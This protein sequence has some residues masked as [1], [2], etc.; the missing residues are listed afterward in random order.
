MESETNQHTYGSYLKAF[1]SKQALALE[2]IAE[3]TK[4]AVHCL[5]AIEE[6]DDDRLP[7]EA[8]VKSFIRSYAEMVGADTDEA[9]SMYL[10]DLKQRADAKKQLLKREAKLSILRRILM[11]AGLIAIILLLV[12]T[13]VIFLE[14]GPTRTPAETN[15]NV[16]P[17]A[18]TSVTEADNN[19][20]PAESSPGKL[21]L[22]VVATKQTWLKV[23]IDSQNAR[24]Y[25]LKPEDRLELEGTKNFN[26]MIGDAT[27]LEILLNDRPVNIYGNSGQVVSLKIP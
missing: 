12:R 7:P 23:I 22:Q 2:T 14:P 8:Y 20:W 25:E 19:E 10:S 17:E 1:R 24:S 9:I 3:Q 6:S 21:K 27:G 15:H 16:I 18:A 4:I 5:R 13:S 11:A 26:L